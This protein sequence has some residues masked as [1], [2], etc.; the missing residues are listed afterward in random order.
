MPDSMKIVA[1]RDSTRIESVA[2][3]AIQMDG[4]SNLSS[5]VISAR[6]GTAETAAAIA[7][8]L[9]NDVVTSDRRDRDA[10]ITEAY[11]FLNSELKRVEADLDGHDKAIADFVTANEDSLPESRTFIQAELV[12]LSSRETMT[13]QSLMELQRERLSLERS[14]VTD[15]SASIVQQLRGAEVALAQARRTLPAGHPEIRRLEETIRSITDGS[16]ETA[17]VGVGR[18]LSMI[19]AQIDNL[20]NDLGEIATRRTAIDAAQNRSPQVTQTYDQMQRTRQGVSDQYAELSRRLAEID[21]LRL[22]SENDQTE[23]M[24]I[25]EP[26]IAPEFPLASNRKRSAILGGF[27]SI[28]ASAGLA[29]AL[30]LMNPVLRNARQFESITGLRPVISLAYRPT[31]QDRLRRLLQLA[32]V[33]AVL[34]LGL[35]AALWMVDLMPQWLADI[36][37][38]SIRA[39]SA[40]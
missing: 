35:A 11:N 10:R 17:G 13:E 4:G 32:Y 27:L 5:I 18:Q 37:P 14:S 23:N 28:A 19:D 6:A 3:S 16:G 21:A 9:A 8:D 20:E 34:L 26:A 24:V 33:I 12:G 36:L 38:P 22:L 29:L 7:N 30:D 2:S 40:A 31:Q 1:L 25:L 39:E 15:D